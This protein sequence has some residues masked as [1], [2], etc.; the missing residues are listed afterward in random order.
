MDFSKFDE[1][2]DTKKLKHDIEEAQKNG[3]G[4]YKEVPGGTYTGKFD[5]L[6]IRET[7]DGRPML[8]AQFRITD[9]EYKNSCLFMNRVL[10]GTKNDANMIASAVGWLESL[11]AE[12]EDGN[13]IPCAFESY[14]QFNQV[15]MDVYENING[16]LE[17]EVA[18]DPE[19][20]NSIG[21]EDIFDVE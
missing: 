4:D 16:I 14:S 20:F 1:Q 17:Y 11:E 19:A 12:D 13:R 8:S 7:K 18:Y 15:V 3:G 10:F 21:I 6:E 5:K 2:I 9:G